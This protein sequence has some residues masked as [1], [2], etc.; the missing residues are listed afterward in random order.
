MKRLAGICIF[1]LLGVGFCFSNSVQAS[2]YL[3]HSELGSTE[4]IASKTAGN[5]TEQLAAKSGFKVVEFQGRR[6]YI[7]ADIDLTLTDAKGMANL[8][9]MQ[10]GLAPIGADGKSINLHHMLQLEPGPMLEINQTLHQAYT[11]QLHGLVE[12]GASFRNNPILRND[13]SKFKKDFWI[14]RAE[15]VAG[16]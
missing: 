13:F 14:W 9:R 1:L 12:D 6:V 4:R 5:L 7:K 2:I 10:H 11:K 15:N 8:E 16:K 3:G